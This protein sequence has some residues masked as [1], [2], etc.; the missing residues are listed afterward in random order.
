MTANSQTLFERPRIP[1]TVS[2]RAV[3]RTRQRFEL[4]S[5]QNRGLTGVLEE[6]K[7]IYLQ[8][9]AQQEALQARANEL[10]ARLTLFQHRLDASAP[11][12]AQQ[13]LMGTAG[14]AARSLRAE[15]RDIERQLSE[16]P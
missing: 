14:G 15:L 12:L 6:A 1:P 5:R 2:T 4:L 8:A 9:V 3:A 7:R 13:T 10:R 16:A 11:A